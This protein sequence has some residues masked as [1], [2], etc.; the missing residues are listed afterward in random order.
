MKKVTDGPKELSSC[1]LEMFI[2]NEQA[3]NEGKELL[4]GDLGKGVMLSDVV[5]FLLTA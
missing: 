1:I 3:K 4:G 5:Y 2:V